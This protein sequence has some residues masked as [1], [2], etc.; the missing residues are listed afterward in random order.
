MLVSLWK[1]FKPEQQ[2]R[3]ATLAPTIP[4]ASPAPAEALRIQSYSRW[5]LHMPQI[6]ETDQDCIQVRAI[7]GDGRPHIKLTTHWSPEINKR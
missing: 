7:G 5:V 3:P 4:D 2:F 6:Q 1:A